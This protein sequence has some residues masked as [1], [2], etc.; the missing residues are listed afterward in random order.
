MGWYASTT[1]DLT[2]ADEE[3]VGDLAIAIRANT[4]L[5][6]SPSED[7]DRYEVVAWLLEQF[8]EESDI[9]WDD[10]NISGTGW[11]KAYDIGEPVRMVDSS[12]PGVQYNLGGIGIYD[13][14]AKHATGVLDWNEEGERF[15]RI[16]FA[17]GKWT[18]FEGEITYKDDINNDL[19]G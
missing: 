11:G 10:F 4:G 8:N 3:A 18:R 16:R 1:W 12:V 14:I 13:V 2:F 15:W 7:F 19:E 5:G 17:D 9:E 6:V